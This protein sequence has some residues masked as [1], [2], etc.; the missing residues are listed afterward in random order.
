[1]KELKRLKVRFVLIIMGMLLAVTSAIFAG[2]YGT[3]HRAESQQAIR[4]LEELA[5]RDGSSPRRIR[6]NG[7][8]PEEPPV[9]MDRDMLDD[10]IR[11]LEGRSDGNPAEFAMFRNSMSLR[12]DTQGQL[13]SLSGA[14]GIFQRNDAEN[15]LQALTE[16]EQNSLQVMIAQILSEDRRSGTLDRNGTA[17]R[18]LVSEKPYGRIITL[19]DRSLELATLNRLLSTL[20]LTGGIGLV[21]LFLASLFLAERAIVPMRRAWERQK[22]FIADASHELKTPL[23]VIAANTDVVLANRQEPVSTQEKWLGY[24]RMETERMAK[25]VND[26]LNIAKLD[27]SEDKRLFLPF[28]LSEAV[29]SACLPLESLSF[30]A[31]RRLLVELQPNLTFTGEETCLSQAVGI[32]VDNAIKHA[33][34]AGDIMV[35]LQREKE[36]GKIKITVQNPGEP[37][38]REETERIFERFYRRDASRARETGG[39]GLGLSIAKSIV[40][41][42]GGT[43]SVESQSKGIN[44]F[45]ITLPQRKGQ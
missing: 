42:H 31:G 44:T 7:F 40:E 35:R 13:L 11:Q 23:T 32:L 8:F 21:L 12:L 38:P 33:S 39:Y 14:G 41:R 24:I 36:S 4:M 10:L 9:S 45:T 3:M 17:Y 26:L 15:P 29:Q 37:I 28:N 19:L 22:Q 16:E 5:A 18:Y 25:L 2:I 1:M 30:E 6:P 20:V 27:A 43:I 34:G